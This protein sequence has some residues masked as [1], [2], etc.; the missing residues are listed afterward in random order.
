MD[1]CAQGTKGP[2]PSCPG[3]E[4]EQTQLPHLL[5]VAV[6]PESSV[7]I[8]M[9]QDFHSQIIRQKSSIVWRRGPWLAM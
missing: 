4:T 6:Y 8:T 3:T 5:S 1:D 7:S 2:C 9:E